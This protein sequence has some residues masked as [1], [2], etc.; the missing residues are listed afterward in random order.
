MKN[1]F[2]A[3]RYWK[4]ISTPMGK[5]DELAKQYDDVIRLSLRDPDLTTDHHI[6]H[7]A[8]QDA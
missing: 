5:V 1:K 7:G 3:K 4:D 8:H 6:I 2:I